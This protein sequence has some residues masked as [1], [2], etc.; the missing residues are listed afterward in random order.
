MKYYH[1]KDGTISNEFDDTKILHREDGPAL[2][3][4]SHFGTPAYEI[5]YKD[6]KDHRSDGPAHFYYS[7]DGSLSQVKY[8]QQGVVHRDDGPAIIWYNK[9]G[10]VE[11]DIWYKDGKMHRLDGPAKILYKQRYIDSVIEKE[12]L[13]KREVFYVINGVFYTKKEYYNSPEVKEYKLNQLI[14]QELNK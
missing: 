2:V 6:G 4:I 7:V 14:N 3:L 12:L 11:R 1:Y 8:Y 13:S 5:W 9:N 10:T